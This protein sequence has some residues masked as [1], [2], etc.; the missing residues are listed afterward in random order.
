MSLTGMRVI[1][2]IALGLIFTVTARAATDRPAVQAAFAN[3]LAEDIWPDASS[4]EVDRKTFEAATDRLTLDWSLPDLRPPGAP[5]A[6]PQRQTQAE[7]RGAGA[8]FAPANL[9]TLSRIGRSRLK[10]WRKTLDQIEAD[11]G[12]PRGIIIAIWGRETAYGAAKL[13]KNGLRTLATLAFMGR[14]K[15][16]Y[17]SEFLAAL[18]MIAQGHVRAGEMKSSWAGAL[19]QPQFLPSKFLAHAV[20]FDGDGKRDIWNSVPDTLASIANY[21]KYFGWTP[22]RG[23]GFEVET[24][25]SLPCTL[26]GPEQ[27][28]S[29]TDWLALGAKRVARAKFTSAQKSRTGYLLM[30]AGRLGPGFIVTDNFYVLKTYNESDLYALFIGHLADR[31]AGGGPFTH[32]WTKTGGFD[33]RDVQLMQIALERQ[34]H[35]VGGADGLIGFKTR[36]AVGKWQARQGRPVTCFPDVRMAKSLR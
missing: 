28:R 15:D 5:K 8:Y 17:R 22:D 1:A 10:K 19:G 6:A 32:P 12:V 35:D 25:Q 29:L 7:F 13:P 34:G 23:W 3:W 11:Y 26:G 14:R 2:A 16:L 33:R 18:D 21:L 9:K 24:P 31:M 4:R 30:P 27:G 36:I 20:D